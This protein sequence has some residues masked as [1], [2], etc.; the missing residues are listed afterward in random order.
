MI[1][2]ERDSLGSRR[3]GSESQSLPPPLPVLF[4]R[5]FDFMAETFI[6]TAFWVISH[7]FGCFCRAWDD[8]ELG[9]YQGA[10]SIVQPHTTSP[11]SPPLHPNS[12]RVCL[13][14]NMFGLGW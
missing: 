8:D 11:C 7:F 14:V 2:R 5:D 9:V 10:Y 3:L 4:H 12:Q 6:L 13:Y 1:K